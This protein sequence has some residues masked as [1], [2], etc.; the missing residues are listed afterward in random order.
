MLLAGSLP[1]LFRRSRQDFVRQ[2]RRLLGARPDRLAHYRACLQALGP[3]RKIAL[4][5]RS[6][7]A[8]T[9][10]PKSTDLIKF[11]PLLKLPGA[12]FVD[13]QYGDT[14]DERRHVEHATG[15]QLLHFDEI[16]YFNDLEDLLAILEACDLLI[17][18]SNATAHLAGALGKRAWLLYP[19]DR[20]PFFYW[21]HGG[22]YRSL[23]YPAVEIVTAAHLDEWQPLIGD[24]AARLAGELR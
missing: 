5:W 1:A 13:V 18:T 20:A 14:V 16:D 6:R 19:G 24:A 3:G 23:W 7:S 22:S 2:P 9:A 15:A 10:R 4:S 21:A 11:A 17:T 8:V 12:H